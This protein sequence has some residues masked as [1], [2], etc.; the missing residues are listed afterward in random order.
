M[1]KKNQK[2]NKQKKK[3]KQM[4]K[5]RHN[6]RK[7]KM[8][9]GARN[10]AVGPV[11]TGRL[12]AGWNSPRGPWVAWLRDVNSSSGFA[13]ATPASTARAPRARS[14]CENTNIYF[15]KPKQTPKKHQRGCFVVSIVSGARVFSSIHMHSSLGATMMIMK[16]KSGEGGERH[17]RIRKK[18]P[19]KR[20]MERERGMKKYTG[21]EPQASK[22]KKKRKKKNERKKGQIKTGRGVGPRGCVFS[23]FHCLAGGERKI[24]FHCLELHSQASGRRKKEKR[25]GQ[26]KKKERGSF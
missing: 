6:P 7:K 5:P 10:S 23:Y 17:G 4:R 16:N 13:L 12:Y 11:H 24:D 26:E 20:E 14:A 18:T 22:K 1:G 3:K 9:P 25:K 2:K 15:K 19:E 8:N 21:R